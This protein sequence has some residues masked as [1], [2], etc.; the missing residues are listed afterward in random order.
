MGNYKRQEISRSAQKGE[1]MK[2]QLATVIT[3]IFL[4]FVV[5]HNA[6]LTTISVQPV[7]DGYVVELFGAVTT[8]K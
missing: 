5:V 7:A 2:K 6:A 8:V 3:T 1:Q 4:T